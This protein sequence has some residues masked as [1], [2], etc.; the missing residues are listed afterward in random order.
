LLR[1]GVPAS[2]V[3]ATGRDTAGIKDLADRG[4]VVRRGRRRAALTRE[5]RFW[6]DGGVSA[7]HTGFGW[8]RGGQL[9]GLATERKG[10][11]CISASEQS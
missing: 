5:I 8:T 7:A 4:V 3:V 1:P 11:P 10:F 9:G 2:E 6:A